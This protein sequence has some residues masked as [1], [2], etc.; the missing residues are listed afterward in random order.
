MWSL[1]REGHHRAS[2]SNI[3]EVRTECDSMEPK[4]LSCTSLC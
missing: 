1:Q 2:T 4:A 3:W